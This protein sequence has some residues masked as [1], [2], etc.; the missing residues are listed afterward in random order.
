MSGLLAFGLSLTSI[1]YFLTCSF[2][3]IMLA[4]RMVVNVALCPVPKQRFFSTQSRNI[5]TNVSKF[6]VDCS[7]CK[8][9]FTV[10]SSER[11]HI[12]IFLEHVALFL[13]LFEGY[14]YL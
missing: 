8:L 2:F 7:V 5:A 14:S 6:T 10:D 13:G 3:S 1:I 12:Y 9:V 11:L 4:F